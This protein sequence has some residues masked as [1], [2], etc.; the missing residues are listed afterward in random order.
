MTHPPAVLEK[1]QRLEQL[2]Q[3]VAAGGSAR[4]RQ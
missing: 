2:L 4:E 3:R 1:A